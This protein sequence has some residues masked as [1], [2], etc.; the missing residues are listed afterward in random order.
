MLRLTVLL[1]KLDREAVVSRTAHR[2]ALHLNVI[3]HPAVKA[4]LQL[5]AKHDVPA[6]VD[7]FRAFNKAKVPVYLLVGAGINGQ[8]VV[9]KKGKFPDVLTEITIYEHVL[10]RLSMLA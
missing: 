2:E 5:N 10:P 7:V 4:W 3:E 8:S 1:C 6:R 9:A